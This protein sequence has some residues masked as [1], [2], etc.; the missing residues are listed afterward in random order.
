[1]KRF[2]VVGLGLLAAL[3]GWFLWRRP[4]NPPPEGTSVSIPVEITNSDP[5]PGVTVI[6]IPSPPGADPS[7]PLPLI[8]EE[9]LRDYGDPAMSP[10][11]DLKLL[12]GLLSN[13]AFLVK[14][15]YDRPMSDNADWAAALLGRNPA[16][17]RFLPDQ[18]RA[19]NAEGLLVDR[20]ETPLFFHPL[21]RGR[22]EIRS[23]GP[24]RKMWTEDDL[25]RNSDGTFRTASELNAPGLFDTPTHPDRP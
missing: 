17:Q 5:N 16:Q 19:L 21:S 25:H 23:A 3:V 11:N 7:D 18:H 10:H 14:N 6:A 2:A 20:W 12:A 1:M 22:Y 24:D 15:V 8:G 13:M 9:M 4:G